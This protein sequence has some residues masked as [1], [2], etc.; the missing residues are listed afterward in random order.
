MRKF[1]TSLLERRYS[2]RCAANGLEG[3]AMARELLPSLIITD[4]MM[5]VMSGYEMTAKIRE[6]DMLRSIPVIMLTART[7]ITEE[8]EGRE[9]GADDFLIK[10]FSLKDLMERI[11]TLLARRGR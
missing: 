8:N 9:S 3:L 2:V 7:E 4:V 1:L 11:G 10:P 6:D 5:P